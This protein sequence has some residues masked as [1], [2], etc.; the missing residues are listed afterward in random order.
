MKTALNSRKNKIFEFLSILSLTVGVVI[1]TGEFIKNDNTPGH[2]LFCTK[3]PWI[4]IILWIL[5]GL[6]CILLMLCFIEISSSTKYKGNGTLSNW[7]KLFISRKMGSFV[8]IFYSFF[9]APII[10]TMFSSMTIYWIMTSVDSKINFNDPTSKLIL[11]FC[12]ILIMFIFS[13]MNT[14]FRKQGKQFQIIGTILKMIPFILIL[15]AGF[16][17]QPSNNVFHDH[18]FKQ[19]NANAFFL[20][21]GPILFS[22]DGFILASNLQKETHNKEVISKALFTGMIMIVTIYILESIALF[23][24]TDTIPKTAG[25]P[26]YPAGSVDSLFYNLFHN[27]IMVKSINWL[28]ILALLVG[29]NGIT[30]AG[31]AYISTDSDNKLI[32]TFNKKI[33]SHTSGTIQFILGVFWYTILIGLGLIFSKSNSDNPIYYADLF[34]NVIVTLAFLSYI[35]LVIGF[36]INRKVKKVAVEKVRGAYSGG[37]IAIIILSI[38]VIYSLYLT[39]FNP[40]AHPYQ[41][42]WEII[43]T[44][45]V[46]VVSINLI[47]FIINEILLLKL[48]IRKNPIIQVKKIPINESKNV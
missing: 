28:I 8:G 41:M 44:L 45:F 14:F 35:M 37:I 39:I 21:V 34:S 18:N 48:S 20:A 6:S 31:P 4:A 19:W 26:L 40:S 9:Y 38:A 30:L 2:I 11:F 47:L 43:S 27:A 7:S 5:I 15:F 22:F 13:M 33:N 16:I 17:N 12:G 10:Y 3:N 46:I 1:G 23:L 42:H 32:Y 36:L 29:M 25:H 24:G